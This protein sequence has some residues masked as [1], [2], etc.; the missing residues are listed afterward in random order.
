MR[1]DVGAVTAIRGTTKAR[2]GGR[3]DFLG[4][5]F[6]GTSWLLRR[7]FMVSL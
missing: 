5:V 7:D 2:P 3:P 4:M 1:R 6:V